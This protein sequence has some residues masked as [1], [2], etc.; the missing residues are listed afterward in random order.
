MKLEF[1]VNNEFLNLV[2]CNDN[3]L[4]QLKIHLNPRIESWFFHPLVKKKL[5]DGRINFLNKNNKIPGG[6]W[7]EIENLCNRFNY[8][9][10]L[11][12]LE[13][14]G[15]IEIDENEF[16]KWVN[17]I[18]ED[19]PKDILELRPYQIDSVYKIIK[20]KRSVSEIATAA[21]KTLIIFL[22]FLY[23]TQEMKL[24]KKLL[25]I[26]PNISLIEQTIN[27]F[28]N[29]ANLLGLS[30]KLLQFQ[31]VL[32]GEVKEIRPNC[33]LV[34]GTYQSLVKLN[35]DFFK[36]IDMVC[37]DECHSATTTS[38]NKIFKHLKHIN[39]RFGLSGTSK[40]KD[41]A[42]A[43]SFTIQ[44]LIGPRVNQIKS[45][46]LSD[47]GYTIPVSIKII[48]LSYLDMDQRKKLHVLKQNKD[49][50]RAKLLSLERQ[51]CINNQNRNEYIINIIN[52]SKTNSLA[53]FH[54]VKD[55]YG[56]YIFEEV[57]EHFRGNDKYKV[58]YVDGDTSKE[59]RQ[60]I[61]KAAQNPNYISIIIA[62]FGVFS[63]GIDIPNIFNIFLLESFKSE[64]IIKQTL[65]RGMR[66]FGDKEVV[67]I[68]DFVD[69]Y[70][71]NSYV[72]YLYRQ[73]KDRI[74]LYEEEHFKYNIIKKDLTNFSPKPIQLNA[75]K[76]L[77]N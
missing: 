65:G 68:F 32:S 55:G 19:I 6:L 51:L 45:K 2:E 71:I 74:L 31:M 66:K 54:N 25:I 26:V 64:I 14:F 27:S 46:Q 47:G 57:Q 77:F 5:W 69:D 13:R 61:R 58:F 17:S 23:L 37:V 28:E 20:N 9:F 73:S 52:Q 39:F 76:K 3:E 60:Y 35:E 1:D 12:G 29:F 38:I 30:N 10:K 7:T 56:K 42:S 33:N 44:S 16:H 36:D 4:N 34:V 49:F 62:S 70:R 59:N 41:E 72:N 22:T 53:L 18:F 63:T 75:S 11:L 8:S 21:G 48:E 40:I 43:N 24:Y 15:N 50:E 67:L